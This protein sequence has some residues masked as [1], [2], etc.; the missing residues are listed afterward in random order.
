MGLGGRGWLPSGSCCVPHPAVLTPFSHLEAGYSCSLG[1]PPECTPADPAGEEP[2]ALKGALAFLS[3]S[4]YWCSFSAKHCTRCWGD[5]GNQ[6]R[7][8]SVYILV[9]DQTSLHIK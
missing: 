5:G 8:A 6:T 3:L 9:L 2:W 1:F 4:T 7:L